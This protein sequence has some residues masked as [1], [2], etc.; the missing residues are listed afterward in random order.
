MSVP[1]E[2]L[3]E[4]IVGVSYDNPTKNAPIVGNYPVCANVT[5]AIG[6]GKLEKIP[7]TNT[8][9]GRYLIIQFQKR[10]SLTLCQVQVLGEGKSVLVSP[11]IQQG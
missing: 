9:T 10:E 5:D 2:R 4:F 7:C 1:G 3:S 6:P 8:V 11:S